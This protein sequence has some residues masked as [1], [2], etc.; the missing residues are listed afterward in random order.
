MTVSHFAMQ[1][2]QEEGGVRL[3]LEGE[4]D[5][6]SVPLLEERLSR[7]SADELAVCLD[8]SKLAFIDSTG[9]HALIRAMNDASANGWH[10]RIA[11]D[12]TPQ[13]IRVFELTH[14]ERLIPG[15]DSNSR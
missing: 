4:L 3:L 11:R 2:S 13:V 5:I 10:L 8:L 15:Y 14:F 12:L 7:L 6:A 1:E 9:L